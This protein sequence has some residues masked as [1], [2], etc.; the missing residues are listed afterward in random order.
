MILAGVFIG[1]YFDKSSKLDAANKISAARLNSLN[2]TKAD[3]DKTKKDLESK[4]DELDQAE[5]DLRG[6]K[7]AGDQATK[8]RDTIASCLKLL[9]EAL[10]AANAGNKTL[11]NQKITEM[12]APCNQAYAIKGI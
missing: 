10:A 3:L 12:Q 1:L 4:Q 7:N 2:T 6:S 11:M 9:T 8:E 5:Q